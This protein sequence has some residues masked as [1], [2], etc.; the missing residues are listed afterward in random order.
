MLV[1]FGLTEILEV[2]NPAL[3]FFFDHILAFC[4]GA[5]VVTVLCGAIMVRRAQKE[6]R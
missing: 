6:Q 1:L 2:I 4:V 3:F 5:V